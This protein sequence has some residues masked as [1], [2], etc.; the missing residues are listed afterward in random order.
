MM[1]ESSSG[2]RNIMIKQHEMFLHKY[3][4]NEPLLV[5]YI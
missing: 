2:L 3:I 5:D 4:D 1:Y